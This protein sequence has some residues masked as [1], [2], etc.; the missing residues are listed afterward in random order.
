MNQHEITET[1][2]EHLIQRA[3]VWPNERAHYVDVAKVCH[4]VNRVYCKSIGD[5]SQPTWDEAPDWQKLSAIN[6][7]LFHLKNPDAGPPGSHENWLKDKQA[8]GWVYGEKKD[9]EA[10]THPCMVPYDQLPKEQQTKDALFVA[11]VHALRG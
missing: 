11:I 6:G 5:D 8:D 2:A 9:P 7:V 10:K 4:E 1:L 3:D